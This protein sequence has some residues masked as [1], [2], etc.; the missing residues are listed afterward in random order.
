MRG[1]IKGPKV[2]FIVSTQNL[3]LQ[4]R[5]RFEEYLT[6]YSI[7]DISG[8]N[9]TEIPLDFL[10]KTHDVVI[11]TAQILLNALVKNNLKISDIT[12]LIFDECHHTNKDHAYNKI[13]QN[14]MA[15]KYLAANEERKLPQVS[16][17]VSRSSCSI[18]WCIFLS[19]PAN[20]I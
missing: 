3:V 18:I 19:L 7:C 16:D 9:S 15:R 14:Y 10:L 5:T 8:S 20:N 6:D 2:V 1:E 12:L 4:Q 13:M 17:G 11:L